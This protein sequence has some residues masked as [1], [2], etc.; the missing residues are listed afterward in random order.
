MSQLLAFLHNCKQIFII[1]SKFDSIYLF[2]KTYSFRR[3]LAAHSGFF[4][5]VLEKL[6]PCAVVYLRGLD[7]RDLTSVL[8]LLYLGRV[9]VATSRVGQVARCLEQLQVPGLVVQKDASEVKHFDSLNSKEAPE[10]AP[11]KPKEEMSGL[12]KKSKHQN[13]VLS[14]KS[15]LVSSLTPSPQLKE[16]KLRQTFS[17]GPE[18]MTALKQV[19]NTLVTSNKEEGR[20]RVFWCKE[21]GKEWVNQWSAYHHVDF[22][23]LLHVQHKC[24]NCQKVFSN[25]TALKL[26]FKIRHGETGLD[27]IDDKALEKNALLYKG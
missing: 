13:R 26:H 1:V 22:Q 23:H 21:C 10:G 17:L 5:S 8:D 9:T 20:K 2:G 25:H 24:S 4:S 18:D 14:K 7:S 19:W 16:E 11:V 6:G 27:S 3:V 15:S 12:N